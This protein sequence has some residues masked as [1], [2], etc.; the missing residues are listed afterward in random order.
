MDPSFP[1]S[2]TAKAVSHSCSK[3]AAGGELSLYSPAPKSTLKDTKG[4]LSQFPRQ[5]VASADSPALCPEPLG[6]GNGQGQCEVNEEVDSSL[7]NSC[8]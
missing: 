4:K 8:P 5:L 3:Q 6:A 2:F 7:G 1:W